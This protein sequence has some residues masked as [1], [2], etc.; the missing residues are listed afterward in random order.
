MTPLKMVSEKREREVQGASLRGTATFR[1][2][3]TEEEPAN[4]MEKQ[5]AGIQ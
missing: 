4:E 5:E 1:G 2:Q 3:G